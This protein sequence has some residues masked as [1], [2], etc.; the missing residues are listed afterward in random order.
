MR[1]IL[2]VA[3]VKAPD[4]GDRRTLILE[5][6]ATLTGGTVVSSQKGMRLDKFN[7]DWFGQARTITVGKDTT[8]IVDGKGDTEKIEARISELKKQIDRPGVSPYEMEKLQ[9]RLAKLI[10]GVAIINVGG[11]TEIEMKEKK[12]RLD[13]A[14][15]ATKAALEEG[16]TPGA[17]VALLHAREAITYDSKD[18]SDFNRGKQIIYRACGKPFNQILNN[19]GEETMD[20]YMTLAKEATNGVNNLVP[21]IE[22]GTLVNAFEEGIIDPTKVVR[23]ALENAAAAAVT[24]LMTECVIHTKPEDKKKGP[25]MDFSGMMG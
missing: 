16:I 2:K 14:L 23:C 8:T 18:S 25:E 3:A 6:I 21:S 4:F 9:E 24:L 13:D 5:D 22:E 11:G 20:Y 15:Q 12:D 7:K 10:G 19:A 17:G 1:G